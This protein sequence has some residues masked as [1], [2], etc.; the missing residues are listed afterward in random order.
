[1][2]QD[3]AGREAEVSSR[4]SWDWGVSENLGV[5]TPWGSRWGGEYW[6]SGT[7]AKGWL[8]EGDP[9]YPPSRTFC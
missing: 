6:G 4:G 2:G 8:H 3:E 7:S 1:M 5:G 9:N